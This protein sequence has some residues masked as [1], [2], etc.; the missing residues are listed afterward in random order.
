MATLQGTNISHL[1]KRKV[2]IQ[3]CRLVGDMLELFSR[4]SQPKPSFVTGILGG[5]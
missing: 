2:I 4:E 3:K 5:G 1:G